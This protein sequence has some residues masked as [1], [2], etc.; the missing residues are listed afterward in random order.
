MSYDGDHA[1]NVYWVIM[2]NGAPKKVTL[3]EYTASFGVVPTETDNS[4]TGRWEGST[5][6]GAYSHTAFAD[7]DTAGGAQNNTEVWTSDQF[8]SSSMF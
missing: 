1:T 2:E 3:E 8:L 5:F 4:K 7:T 6:G